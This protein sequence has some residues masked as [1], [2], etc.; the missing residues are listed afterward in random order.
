MPILAT[1]AHLDTD[2][3]ALDLHRLL[4][5]AGE[6]G[7]YVLVPHSYGGV[8]ATLFARTWPTDVDG[9][10]MV[11]TATQLMREIVSPEAVAKW[12]EFNRRSVPEAPEAVMLIDAFAKITP[13]LRCANCQQW[14]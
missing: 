6:P 7:P 4:T 14:C 10:V 8:I 2:Q 13:L 3:Q 1:L 12:D 9:L 5:A 11:D